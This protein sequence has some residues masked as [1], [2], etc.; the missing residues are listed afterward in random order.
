M[1]AAR[2][3]VQ[4]EREP[5][6]LHPD[7]FRIGEETGA[8]AR[9]GGLILGDPDATR[10]GRACFERLAARIFPEAPTARVV[11]FAKWLTWLFAFD[12][13]RDEGA[14]GRSG[15]AIDALYTDLLKAVRRGSARPGAGPFEAALADLWQQTAPMMGSEWRRR[16]T[17]HLEWHR[18]GCGEEAVNRRTGAV[19]ALEDYPALRRRTNGPFMFDLAEP[20]VGTE[21]PEALAASRTWQTLVE[22][23]GDLMAWCNDVAS[24]ALG[25]GCNYVTVAAGSLGL[26]PAAAADWVKDQ[27]TLRSHDVQAAARSLPTE[28]ARLRLDPATTRA[29]GGLACV[30]LAAPRAHFDWLVESG[31]YKPDPMDG[32]V[33]TPR[34]PDHQTLAALLPS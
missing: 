32:S 6:R 11:L 2:L 3:P 8:W 25:D 23:T 34:R 16:F 10:L 33:P 17:G 4:A 22:G 26:E 31:R 30:L 12:D 21:V 29:I 24:H 19:P 7:V 9:N 1:D 14:L 18:D 27:I 5:C 28:F 15:S 13:L 20:V